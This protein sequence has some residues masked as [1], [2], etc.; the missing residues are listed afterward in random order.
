MIEPYEC[1]HESRYYYDEP[2]EGQF[3]PEVIRAGHHAKYAYELSDKML[4]NS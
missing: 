4:Y 3:E 1:G 2:F